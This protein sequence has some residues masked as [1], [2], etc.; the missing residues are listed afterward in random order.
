MT[1]RQVLGTTV[2]EIKILKLLIHENV[3]P[4]LDIVVDREHSRASDHSGGCSAGRN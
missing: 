3:V 1:S 4:L 2:R